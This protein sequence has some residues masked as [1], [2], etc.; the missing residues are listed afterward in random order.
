MVKFQVF[1]QEY[2][3][4]IYIHCFCHSLNLA[5]QDSCMKLSFVRDAL[6]TIQELSYLIKYSGKRKALLEKLRID[7]HV[8]CDDGPTLRPLCMTR[9]TFKAKSFLSVLSIYEALMQTMVE[10]VQDKNSNFDVTAKAGGI[11]RSMESFDLL[12]G[13]MLKEIVFFID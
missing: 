13:F 11:H 4:A 8:S 7:L 5:V 9:W 10:I 12:F 2:P 1:R 6:S 3:K